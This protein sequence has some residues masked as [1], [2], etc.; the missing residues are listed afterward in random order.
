MRVENLAC[1][2]LHQFRFELLDGQPAGMYL[3]RHGQVNV[4]AGIDSDSPFRCLLDTLGPNLYVI[5]WPQN[6]LR[7]SFRWRLR[8]WR[9]LCGKRAPGSRQYWHENNTP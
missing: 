3:A 9:R 2:S 5:V 7:K 8:I 4:S 6:V 1:K